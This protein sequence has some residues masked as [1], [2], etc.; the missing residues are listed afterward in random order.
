MVIVKKL[1]AGHFFAICNHMQ[2]V[3]KPKI[4]NQGTKASNMSFLMSCFWPMDL[5]KISCLQQGNSVI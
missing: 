5:E 3:A 1:K 4:L 2:A